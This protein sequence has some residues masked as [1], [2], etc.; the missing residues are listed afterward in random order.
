MPLTPAPLTLAVGETTDPEAVA[1]LAETTA[2]VRATEDEGAGATVEFW[3]PVEFR[4]PVEVVTATDEASEVVLRA[5][6]RTE[7]VGTA[8]EVET[9]A[10]ELE[11]T[12]EEITEEVDS[13]EVGSAEVDSTEVGSAEVETTEEVDSAEEETTEEVETTASV[14]ETTASDSMVAAWA[15]TTS[16]EEDST[17]AKLAGVSRDRETVTVSRPTVE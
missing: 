8:E 9:T 15:D 7:E 10:E 6:A 4:K 2:V 14:V 17:T 12:E 13:T 3:K 1:L 11:T 5:M 16:S